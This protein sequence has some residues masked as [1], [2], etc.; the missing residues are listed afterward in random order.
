MDATAMIVAV[1]F[2]LDRS[3]CCNGAC[4]K[5]CEQVFHPAEGGGQRVPSGSIWLI[6][7]NYCIAYWLA[8]EAATW[9]RV[10]VGRVLFPCLPRAPTPAPRTIRVTLD[11]KGGGRAARGQYDNTKKQDTLRTGIERVQYREDSGL[12]THEGTSLQLDYNGPDGAA[13]T[14]RSG[15]RSCSTWVVVGA[16]VAGQ[17]HCVSVRS[18][19]RRGC[20]NHYKPRVHRC[21]ADHRLVQ[22]VGEH[23][24]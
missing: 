12:D 24:R 10:C 14:R 8:T 3:C 23:F 5:N 2:M 17:C 1:P 20:V 19:A 22:R 15:V 7:W 9:G 13:T 18:P 6:W 21:H 16:R 11:R 4:D